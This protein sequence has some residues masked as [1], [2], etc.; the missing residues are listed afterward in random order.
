MQPI[1]GVT[2]CLDDNLV[3]AGIEYSFIR[4]QYGE[5]LKAVGAQPIFIDPSIDP[6]VAAGICDGVVISGGQDIHPSLYG[7]DL[8]SDGKLEPR[9]RVDWEYGLIAELEKLN[10]PILGVCYGN[11]LLNVYHGGTL[12]QDIQTEVG[13]DIAHGSTLD[14]ATHDVVFEVD[15]LGFKNGEMKPVAARHH[16]AVRDL[17]D[18]FVVA[19]RSSDGVIEAIA[20][21]ERNQYGVQWHTESDGSAEQVYGQ[22]VGKCQ[23]H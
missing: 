22:F 21:P 13:G 7:Q 10:K 3:Q 15:F 5:A 14:Q 19:A 16:Q 6:Q 20:C 9:S 12:Y 23:P 4:R 18:G 8:K 1:I 11:Q 17:G 2:M